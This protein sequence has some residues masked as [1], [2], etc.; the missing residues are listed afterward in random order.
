MAIQYI[1][2][3]ELLLKTKY[4][5]LCAVLLR[6][7]DLYLINFAAN[8]VP[9]GLLCYYLLKIGNYKDCCPIPVLSL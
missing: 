6:M 8:Q 2:C 1:V 7:K 4:T 9:L 3:V 5:S